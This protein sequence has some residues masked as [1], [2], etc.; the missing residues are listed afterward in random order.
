MTLNADKVSDQYFKKTK[1]NSQKTEIDKS[2]N[3]KKLTQC[4]VCFD[5]K[6]NC[7]QEPCGHIVACQ[8]CQIE[9]FKKNN[10]KCINCREP[11]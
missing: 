10:R 9:I 11:I 1:K 7:L 2:K 3:I 4:V 8:E 5:N 6:A